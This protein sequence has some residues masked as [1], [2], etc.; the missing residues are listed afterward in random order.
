MKGTTITMVISMTN[1]TDN[2]PKKEGVMQ[3]ESKPF[4]L[5]L[6]RVR[7]PLN[8]KSLGIEKYDGSTNPVE[9]L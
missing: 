6:K 3:E 7:W 9:W 5:N 4:S 2:A 8:F 1:L